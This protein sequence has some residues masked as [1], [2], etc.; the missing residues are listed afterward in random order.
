MTLRRNPLL[1]GSTVLTFV[2]YTT[3]GVL[4][5]HGRNPLLIGST[6]LTLFVYN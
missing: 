2:G 6:V 3:W 5:L 4:M 1:I